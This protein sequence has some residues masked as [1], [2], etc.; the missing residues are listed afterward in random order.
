MP[1][2]PPEL[3]NIETYV[4]IVLFKAET[5]YGVVDSSN[6]LI[7]AANLVRRIKDE[8]RK[9]R[10]ALLAIE[11]GKAEE[12]HDEETAKVLRTELAALIKEK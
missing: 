3:K 7:E 4:K 10:K 6:R 8:Q 9:Q 1:E 5:R 12:P 11:L 2:T